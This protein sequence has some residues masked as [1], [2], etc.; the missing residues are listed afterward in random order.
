MVGHWLMGVP[1]S[2]MKLS[3][4]S[5]Q[6]LLSGWSSIS[7][8]RCRFSTL[9]CGLPPRGLAGT[10]P[11]AWGEPPASSTPLPML[12]GLGCP[13]WGVPGACGYP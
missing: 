3:S 7:Y 13:E 1:R 10:L 8:R 12:P 6:A 9:A 11:Q 5:S 4:L 2:S